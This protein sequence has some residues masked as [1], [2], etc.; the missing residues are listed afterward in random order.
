MRRYLQVLGGLS[1]CLAAAGA[2]CFT[3]IERH[4]EDRERLEIMQLERQ[5]MAGAEATR[6]AIQRILDQV[7]TL[8][9]LGE[10]VRQQR[11]HGR[12]ELVTP[13]E[14]QL[15][16]MTAKQGQPVR[17]LALIGVSGTL[18]WS[19]QPGHEAV[20]LSDREHFRVH[21]E[22]RREPFI[23]EPLVGRVSG[24]WS[25][26]ATRRLEWAD[27][28]FDG[29]VVV[30]L[31]PA[32]ISETLDT[33]RAARSGVSA[34]LRA[35]GAFLA[36]SAPSPLP[37]G[38]W[39]RRE[40]LE[41]L[42]AQPSGTRRVVRTL[43]AQE[44]ILSWEAVP[45][46]PLI[47]T[48]GVPT[49]PVLSAISARRRELQ[50]GVGT[51]LLGACVLLFLAWAMMARRRALARAEAEH[52]GI[53]AMIDALPGAAYVATLAPDGS[54]SRLRPTAALAAMLGRAAG[55]GDWRSYTDAEGMKA[56]AEAG[57]DARQRGAGV[58]E[59]RLVLEGGRSLWVRDH[60][61]CPFVLRGEPYEVVGLLLDVT[62]QRAATAKA[63]TSAKLAVLGEMATGVAH[64]INQPAAT[65]ALAADVAHLQLSRGTMELPRTLDAMRSISAQTSRIREIIRRVQLFGRGD[66][67]QAPLTPV[68]LAE[69]LDGALVLV[70]GALADASIRLEVDL[71]PTLPPLR[72]RLVAIEQVLANIL[73]NSRDALDAAAPLGRRIQL[74]S[75]YEAAT[76]FVE[77][78]VRDTGPGFP[79][80]LLERVFEPFVTTK[81][82]GRG[83]GLGLAIVYGIVSGFAGRIR[84]CNGDD[85][86]GAVVRFSLPIWTGS[87]HGNS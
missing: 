9:L 64:E 71:P 66:D 12:I 15:E 16:E 10:V 30:S 20:D 68:S 25:I 80:E 34:L 81:P 4:L 27:G 54:L 32:D 67:P 50:I 23:S 46:W 2:V 45:G 56:C 52:R 26:Q 28:T 42:L 37:Y 55:S 77:V 17:Q 51:L 48:F 38:T 13:L 24:R 58:A 47:A 65:I 8:G 36:R 87:N 61:R 40:N 57:L 11:I 72:A 41:A 84:A 75:R 74:S 62:E 6:Q 22:G 49:E 14:R 31:D 70:R 60:L 33:L 59:Y 44:V 43:M 78:V 39:I 86:W 82:I 53:Q 21:A 63:M 5:S 18:L 76:G 85:G 29:V 7:T 83:T 3:W 79:T 73:L 69:A 19:S 1:L 35:D